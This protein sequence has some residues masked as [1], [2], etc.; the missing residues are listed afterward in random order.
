MRIQTPQGPSGSGFLSRFLLACG[1]L[2]PKLKKQVDDLCEALTAGLRVALQ[3]RLLALYVHGAVTFP[4]TTH[5]GDLDFH[6]I[7]LAVPTDAER[8]A[9]S[10]LSERLKQDFP[11]L[12]Q[13][14]DGYY[15]LEEDA[16]KS[17][18]PR[19]LLRPDLVDESWALH[20]AHMLAGR[21]RVLHGPEPKTIFLAPTWRELEAAL[22][23]ELAYVARCLAQYPAYCVHNL[24]RLMY[25]HETRDVV[26]SK[27]AA[28]S[29]ASERF[30]AFRPLIDAALRSYAR[31]EGEVDRAMLSGG[32]RAFY[33]FALEVIQRARTARR[34]ARGA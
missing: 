17:A 3:E 9:I 26:T 5:V 32:V 16:R 11:P 27:S 7:L 24:C 23:G 14:L 28:A 6:A 15:I 1:V 21:V 4:E 13:E 18:R 22:E 29:W 2:D 25:S 20:R 8:E 34:R 33:D 19:H 30:A 31:S 12:G 10:A